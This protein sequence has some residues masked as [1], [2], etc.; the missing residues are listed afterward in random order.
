[1]SFLTLLVFSFI[2]TLEVGDTV[3]ESLPRN[4]S[5]QGGYYAEAKTLLDQLRGVCSFVEGIN[6]ATKKPER[7]YYIRYKRSGKMVEEKAGRASIDNMTPAKA[8][9][10]RARRMAGDDATNQEKREKVQA[11]KDRMTIAR[12][13][14]AYKENRPGLKGLVTDEN[15]FKLH[16]KPS[17]GNKVPAEIVTLDV[18]RLRL[19]MLK[20]RK[21]ATVRNVIELLRRIV[22]FGGPQGALSSA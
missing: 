11:K 2:L 10:L 8:N 9:Q 4:P 14:E 19:R 17:F 13:W 1:M 12:L 18:D 22:N 20:T 16:I 6:P 15:R 21:P 5:A 3:G 7:V